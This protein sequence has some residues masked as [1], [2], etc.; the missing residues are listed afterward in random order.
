MEQLDVRYWKLELFA[1]REC[2]NIHA[3][4]F[5]IWMTCERV[6]V[7][8]RIV[9]RRTMQHHERIVWRGT[10]KRIDQVVS[11]TPDAGKMILDVATINGD[12]EVGSW[13][14]E[15]GIHRDWATFS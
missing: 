5:D 8:A 9:T 10:R 14:L 13:K 2:W 11:V 6:D 4:Q 12:S 7:I 3:V 1:Q 15:I